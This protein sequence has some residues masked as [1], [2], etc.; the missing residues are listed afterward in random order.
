[1]KIQEG[2]ML[3]TGTGREGEPHGQGEVE[4]RHSLL[5]NSARRHRRL[6]VRR[7]LALAQISK[8]AAAVSGILTVTVIVFFSNE[9][10]LPPPPE[11]LL[12]LQEAC[13][14]SESKTY[15][16]N[17]NR[18][19]IIDATVSLGPCAPADSKVMAQTQSLGLNTRVEL[20]SPTFPG[21][22][23]P[24]APD[25]QPLDF[26]RSSNQWSWE[27]L[28]NRPGNYILTMRASVHDSEGVLIR[29]NERIAVPLEVNGTFSYYL[30][31]VGLQLERFFTSL[32]GMG[33]SVVV[34]L[35]VIAGWISKRRKSAKSGSHPT[36]PPSG[37]G[38][39]YI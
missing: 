39:R 30:G 10:S 29:A 11:R 27:I 16:A 22:I 34:I 3:M 32:A 35:G 9:S 6:S 4:H 25:T 1:V 23:E 33:V 37:Y 14:K 36:D 19:V 28:G 26:D 18:T 12:D 2:D 13:L 8:I 20:L 38:S 17:V 21:Q 7:R 24:I 31:A 15:H 5:K